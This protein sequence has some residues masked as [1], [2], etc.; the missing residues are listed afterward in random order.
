MF[1]AS[2]LLIPVQYVTHGSTI[3]FLLIC[4][5]EPKYALSSFK[6]WIFGNE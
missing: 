1:T 2:I 4:L 5:V 6:G 3:R